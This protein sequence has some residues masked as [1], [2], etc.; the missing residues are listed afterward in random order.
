MTAYRCIFSAYCLGWIIYSG[1]H[2]ANGA[3]K[4]FIYLTNWAFTFVTMY[5]LWASVVSVLHHFGITNNQVDMQMKAIGNHDSDAE[6]GEGLGDSVHKSAVK[7]SWYHKGLWVVFNIAANTAIMVTLLYWTLIF[8]GTTSGLDVS[9]HLINSVMIVADIMLS[10]V[11]VRILHVVYPLVL[12]IC[13]LLT[14]VI[15]WAVD[16]TNARGEPYIYSYIDYNN[17]PGFS[18]GLVCGFILVGQPMVQSLLFG[19]YKLRCFLGLKCGKKS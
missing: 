14:T 3:E 16:A 6:G 18:I 4:W 17:S 8:G 11:P 10:C 9:T 12:G 2:P 5:F 1:F 19:L 13:Y 7:M 15:F